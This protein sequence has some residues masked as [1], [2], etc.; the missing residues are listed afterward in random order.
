[1]R[2]ISPSSPIPSN[3][4]FRAG[5]NEDA[6]Q[7][8]ALV[9]GVLQEYGLIPEP[10]GVD[11][12]LKKVEHSYKEGYFGIVEDENGIIATYGLYPLSTTSV[13]IRKMYAHPTAR[14]NG[15]GKWMVQHLIEIA[16]ANGYSE[17]ELETATALKEAIG[18]Y[19]KFGFQE[20][21]FENKTPRCDK[22]FYLNI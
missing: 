12:D 14:G 10:D 18:L 16:K 13:E 11:A 22:S 17:V 19:K 7:L 6:H 2:I 15:L 4:S 1:M 20:K 5:K 8:I 3:Y 21:N 9:H